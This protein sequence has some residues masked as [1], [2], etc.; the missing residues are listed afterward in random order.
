MGLDHEQKYF[1]KIF[2]GELLSSGE[3]LQTLLK[4]MKLEC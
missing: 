4:C 2:I 1:F 3:L